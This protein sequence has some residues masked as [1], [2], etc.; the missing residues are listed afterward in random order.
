[1]GVTCEVDAVIH[2]YRETQERTQYLETQYGQRIPTRVMLCKVKCSCGVTSL[3]WLRIV[4][5]P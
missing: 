5:Q 2:R 4:T 3:R 1:M